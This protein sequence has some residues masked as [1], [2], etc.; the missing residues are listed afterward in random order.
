MT[1]V[2]DKLLEKVT[3]PVKLKKDIQFSA[4][5]TAVNPPLDG[6]HIATSG[7]RGE[8]LLFTIPV[9]FAGACGG[10]DP[11]SFDTSNAEVQEDNELHYVGLANF[12]V[13]RIWK[14][15][16]CYECRDPV[17]LAPSAQTLGCNLLEHSP[18]LLNDDSYAC[19]VPYQGGAIAFEGL[20]RPPGLGGGPTGVRTVTYLVE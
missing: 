17:M 9:I 2:M 19:P 5:Q 1:T 14:G 6:D 15:G 8:T 7:A 16:D 10:F 20:I 11:S 13:T 3:P 18:S 4:A 12:L